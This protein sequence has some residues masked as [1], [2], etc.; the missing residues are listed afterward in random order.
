MSSLS[1]PVPLQAER[2]S[3]LFH[4]R[5]AMFYEGATKRGPALLHSDGSSHYEE[6]SMIIV[7][8][9]EEDHFP[10]EMS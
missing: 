3:C 6:I 5:M 2:L 1:I 10:R 7:P 9:D 4:L 8:D